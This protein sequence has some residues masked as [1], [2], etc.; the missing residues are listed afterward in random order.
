MSRDISPSKEALSNR[1]LTLLLE[2]LSKKETRKSIEALAKI[3]KDEWKAIATTAIQLKAFVALGGTSELA[4][5]LTTSVGKTIKLQIESLLSPLTNEINQTITDILTPFISDLLTPLINDM[6]TFMSENAV[7]AGVGG[8]AGGV[9]GLFVGS[10]IVGAFIGSIVGA[11]V[12]SAIQAWFELV[13]PPAEEGDYLEY[14]QEWIRETG[15]GSLRQY[16]EWRNERYGS[17]ST[18]YIPPPQT[19][20]GGPQEDF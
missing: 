10:P 5:T 18:P 13:E 7:G 12:S 2:T 20:P 1:N 15:G 17:G 3:D 9:I 11:A 6:T 16:D 14:Y 19:R 4:T 8:I